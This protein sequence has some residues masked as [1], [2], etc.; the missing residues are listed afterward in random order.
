[1]HN[2]FL[3]SSKLLVSK[4]PM[5]YSILCSLGRGVGEVLRVVWDPHRSGILW[6]YFPW[7]IFSHQYR[8]SL[9]FL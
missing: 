1:M 2:L 6:P 3:S 7:I 8:K 4:N 9:Y 5:K